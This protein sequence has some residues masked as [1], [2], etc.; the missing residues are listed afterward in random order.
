MPES[1]ATSRAPYQMAHDRVRAAK[2]R[3][4]D[5]ECV[6]GCGQK[7]E[8]WALREDPIADLGVVRH[9]GKALWFSPL[10]EDYVAMAARCHKRAD[11]QF[12]SRAMGVRDYV[13]HGDGYWEAPH[14]ASEPG[15]M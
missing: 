2:G 14:R 1:I 12:R 9:E 8:H 3:P 6:D 13:D 7:A 11:Q 4:G 15:P 5:Y 10:V